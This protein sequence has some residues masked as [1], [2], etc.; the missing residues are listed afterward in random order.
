[1]DMGVEAFFDGQGWALSQHLGRWSQ[2]QR[3]IRHMWQWSS[4]DECVYQKIG[5]DISAYRQSSAGPFTFHKIP[6]PSNTIPSDCIPA[7][8]IQTKHGVKL[9]RKPKSIS[10]PRVPNGQTPLLTAFQALP[11]AL[12]NLLGDVYLPPDDGY[13]IAGLIREVHLMCGRDGSKK[14]TLSSHAFCI[15]DHLSPNHLSGGAKCFGRPEHM[16]SLRAES[17]GALAIAIS[18]SVI[19]K[20]YNIS[21]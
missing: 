6:A 2:H 7:E 10:N 21:G 12:R 13:E 1:M 20:V 14:N 4:R 16:S 15:N 5:D 9:V 3:H 11:L 17:F 19:A 18:L 8:V